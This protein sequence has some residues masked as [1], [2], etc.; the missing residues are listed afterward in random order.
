MT[1]DNW[2]TANVD[3]EAVAELELLLSKLPDRDLTAAEI[4]EQ[5]LSLVISLMPENSTLTYDQVEELLAKHF[6]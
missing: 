1:V 6:G 2:A 3:A 5:R 4:R